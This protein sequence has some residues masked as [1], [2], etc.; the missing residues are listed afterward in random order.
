MDKPKDNNQNDE[1]YLIDALEKYAEVMNE[2]LSEMGVDSRN[3][4]REDLHDFART[5][6]AE[7]QKIYDEF[8]LWVVYGNDK[9][10][11]T[12]AMLRAMRNKKGR[13]Y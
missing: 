5:G 11:Q 10:A 3:Y 13:L 9:K 1:V 6:F 4:T 8:V 7:F 2:L 12:R